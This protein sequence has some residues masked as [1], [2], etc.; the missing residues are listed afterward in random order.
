M[1][2]V[3]FGVDGSQVYLYDDINIGPTCCGCSLSERLPDRT[4]AELAEMWVPAGMDREFYRQRWAPDFATH[5]VDAMLAHIG[6]HRAAGHV[7][8]EWVD[9]LLRDEWDD[10]HDVTTTAAP[11]GDPQ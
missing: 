3:R 1:S 8:P 6:E 11:G 9:G 7:I 4:D 2:F 10:D 5:N